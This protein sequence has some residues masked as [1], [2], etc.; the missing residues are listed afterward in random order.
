MSKLDWLPAVSNPLTPYLTVGNAEAA[1]AFYER[2]FGFARGEMAM[3]D[4]KGNIVHGEL[5]YHGRSIAMLAP[6]G[7]WGGTDRTPAHAGI[8]LPLSFYVYCP[9]VDRVAAN[10]TAAGATVER[11]PE[12]MF[13]GDR[14][15][16]IR[17]PDGYL[18]MFATKKGEFDPA[19]AP[20]PPT[21]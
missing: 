10:A 13:W 16:M 5:Y 7:A 21:A 14:T 15:A 17:D 9:D 12:D 18:W 6:E 11:P 20:K 2:A 8:R 1:L 3:R 4:D 19:K